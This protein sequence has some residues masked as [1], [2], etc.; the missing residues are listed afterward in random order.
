MITM[1]LID[2]TYFL[3]FEEKIEV[4]FNNADKR[5]FEIRILLLGEMSKLLPV[6]IAVGGRGYIDTVAVS[7]CSVNL[8]LRVGLF[9]FHSSQRGAR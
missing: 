9:L 4:L 3:W 2:H 5:F 8:I 7:I 6:L 1:V